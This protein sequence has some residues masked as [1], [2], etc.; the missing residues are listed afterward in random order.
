MIVATTAT[1]LVVWGADAFAD[2]MRPTEIKRGVRQVHELACRDERGR[3]R[4]EAIGAERH[5][6][7][8]DTALAGEIEEDVVGEIASRRA[9]SRRRE[10]DGQFVGGV[11]QGVGNRYAKRA[12]VAFFAV[13]ADVGEADC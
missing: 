13:G 5:A 3:H 7:V 4:H 6:V 12:G 1:Q 9:V 10:V 8:E 2:R 11:G